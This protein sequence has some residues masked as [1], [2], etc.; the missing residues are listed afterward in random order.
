MEVS[1]TMAGN[2]NTQRQVLNLNNGEYI[3]DLKE[4]VTTFILENKRVLLNAS[5][6]TGKTQYIKSL[7][8]E[9]LGQT[10]DRI[11]FCSPFLVIQGQFK[12]SLLR[13]D[14]E[15][16]LEIN[17]YLKGEINLMEHRIITSTFQGLQRIKK[18]IQPTDL[19][20]V[21]EAHELL[22]YYTPR[23]LKKFHFD[24]V[25]TLYETSAHVLLLSG[26]P[27]GGLKHF[28]NLKELK[29]KSEMINSKIGIQYSS[30]ST[31]SEA[32]HFGK[33]CISTYGNKSVNFIYIKNRSM[34]AK[35]KK[36]LE[37]EIDC[38]VQVFTSKHKNEEFYGEFLKEEKIKEGIQFVISTNAISTGANIKNRN[39]GEALMFNT[40]DAVEIIQFSKRFRNKPDIK[41]SIINKPHNIKKLDT[42]KVKKLKQQ[43]KLFRERQKKLLNE[44]EE[45]F[46]SIPEKKEYDYEFYYEDFGTKSD[47]KNRVL[48]RS[49]V[50]EAYFIDKIKEFNNSPKSLE[51]ELNKKDGIDVIDATFQNKQLADIKLNSK[52][53]KA[54]EKRVAKE[55][56]ESFIKAPEE[57]LSSL[58]SILELHGNNDIKNNIIRLLDQCKDKYEP[59][60]ESDFEIKKDDLSI[61][62]KSVIEPLL[63]S[64]QYIK[65]LS[66]NLY[67]LNKITSNKR[68][69]VNLT[70][71]FNSKLHQY[72]QIENKD[73]PKL[74]L[75]EIAIE[76]SINSYDAII[77]DLLKAT[78]DYLLDND[79]VNYE[80][81]GIFLKWYFQ[82]QKFKLD[83][84]KDEPFN[85]KNV[86][87]TK[88]GKIEFVSK[89]LCKALVKSIFLLDDKRKERTINGKRK[90]VYEFVTN[91]KEAK[92]PKTDQALALK[93]A[94]EHL[95][96]IDYKLRDYLATGSI[97]YSIGSDVKKQPEIKYKKFKKYVNH[98]AYIIE[99]ILDRS[100]YELI[101]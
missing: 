28:L 73:K 54:Y 22:T 14:L 72:L 95:T 7:C 99:S 31:L 59:E 52:E 86:K 48:K 67:Y 77:I 55:F 97:L 79:Y 4:D 16:D 65:D 49:L 81:V 1:K 74:V 64:N 66:K 2:L 76:P 83:R 25:S 9:R 61:I 45:I 19:V 91:L 3:T 46:N 43:R 5:P 18:Q 10:F 23:S 15:V 51:V 29:I 17:R 24:I 90:N 56:T 70:L 96:C 40:Y 33:Y 101:K 57:V 88:D 30:N 68:N 100:Y 35:I 41:V 38:K 89:T 87:S 34:C 26:T 39:I 82:K 58:K 84:F 37:S 92:N 8:K 63:E 69:V 93:K 13:D 6:G 80:D 11:I 78:F 27:Y 50:E 32:V 75:K 47:L 53:F 12:N 60:T 21:D 85:L 42:S 62:S 98:R 44:I 36:A 71:L 94:T 20:V